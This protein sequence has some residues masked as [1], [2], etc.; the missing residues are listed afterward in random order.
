MNKDIK[1][2]KDGVVCLMTAEIKTNMIV[3]LKNKNV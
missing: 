2:I 3:L 1:N